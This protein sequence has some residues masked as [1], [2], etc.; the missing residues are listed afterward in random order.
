[1]SEFSLLL[2]ILQENKHQ[3]HTHK[4]YNSKN[5]RKTLKHS[6]IRRNNHAESVV[7]HVKKN[8]C[9]NAFCVIIHRTN[10]NPSD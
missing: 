8:G 10:H 1:M 2:E 4:H 5:R 9:V 3:N 6:L 7:N